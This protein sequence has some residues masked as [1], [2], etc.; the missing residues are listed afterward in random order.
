MLGEI[1]LESSGRITNV[2]VLENAGERSK[3][4]VT[5][6]GQG[7]LLG[8][9][10]AEMASYWQEIRPGHV[11]YGEGGPVWMTDEG[12]V[13]SWKGFGVGRPTGP[14]FS[15]RFA[16]AGAIQ[17]SSERYAGLAGSALVGEYNVDEQGNYT[18]T[19]WEWK[20]AQG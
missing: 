14:G 4:E 16:V 11:L 20:A 6:Q 8:T 10:M 15:A 17:T 3:I 12:D 19:L 1:V 13:L 2:K 5:V 7:K 18:W 9:G